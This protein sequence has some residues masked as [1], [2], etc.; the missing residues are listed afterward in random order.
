MGKTVPSARSGQPDESV[1]VFL[2]IGGT[3]ALSA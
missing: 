2:G 1:V 3:L